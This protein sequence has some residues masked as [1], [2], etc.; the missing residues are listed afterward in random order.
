MRYIVEN[1]DTEE[2]IATFKTEEERQR[3]IDSNVTEGYMGDVRISIYE[4]E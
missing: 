3:W 1:W 4:E 2:V